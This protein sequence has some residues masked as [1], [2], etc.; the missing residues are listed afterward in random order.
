MGI[1]EFR[2][3]YLC[4]FY[5]SIRQNVVVEEQFE[6]LLEEEVNGTKDRQVQITHGGVLFKGKQLKRLEHDLE[7]KF[8]N[9][10]MTKLK[11][12]AEQHKL[13]LVDVMRR[14]D[15]DNSMSLDREEFV[16]GIAVRERLN[17][18]P[19]DSSHYVPNCCYW[20]HQ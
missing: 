5:P 19:T 4:P 1:Y 3:W 8:H 12:Y 13:R 7:A 18:F 20:R 15:K 6:S 2:L 10:P 9:D 11:R 17:M 16:N 14:F